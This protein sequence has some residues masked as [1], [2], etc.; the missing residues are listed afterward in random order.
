VFAV[1]DELVRAIVTILV[2]HVN[3][4]EIERALLK[5]PAASEAY[6]YYLRGVLIGGIRLLDWLHHGPLDAPPTG[7]RRSRRRRTAP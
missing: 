1:E 5:P 2:A 7:G 3:R 4:A 6:E